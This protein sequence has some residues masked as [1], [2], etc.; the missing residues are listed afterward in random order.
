MVV[1]RTVRAVLA[2]FAVALLVGS[3]TGTISYGL[4]RSNTAL[5]VH[6]DAAGCQVVV[7]VS[8]VLAFSL[9][10]N[11]C[12]PGT[13]IS[14]EVLQTDSVTHTFTLLSG[15]NTT[16]LPPGNTTTQIMAYLSTHP[17]LVNITTG[18]TA[19]GAN[20]VN[21][22]APRVG[23]Y[24]YVC[25]IDGHFSAGMYGQIGIG[26]HPAGIGGAS[27]SPGAPVFIITGTIAGLVVLAIV[28]GF[29]V[30]RRR[31]EEEMPPERLG[32]PEPESSTPLQSEPPNRPGVPPPP[33]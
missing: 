8:S 12:N 9:N 25:L 7:S 14:I 13:T 30:G 26:I 16:F 32:Y 3:W 21:I 10:N 27:S 29:V 15:S 28:L 11:F 4:A 24:E 19:G 22:T 33:P 1:V 17:P 20:F 18:S 31:T 23:L 2:V 6:P 5:N